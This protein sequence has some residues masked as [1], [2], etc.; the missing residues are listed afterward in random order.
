MQEELPLLFTGDFTLIIMATAAFIVAISVHEAHHAFVATALGDDTP[1]MAGRLTLNPIRHLDMTGV[2][3]FALAGIGWGWTPVNPYKL[4]P[5]PR[6]GNAIVAAA[7]PLSNLALAVV[8]A[9]LYHALDLPRFAVPVPLVG[10]L[11]LSV[12]FT[13]FIRIVAVLNVLLFVLNLIP[14]PP[15]DGFSVLLG[16]L[17]RPM[18]EAIRPIE[19]YGFG[20]IL[21]LLFAPSLLFGFS[22]VGG[23]YRPAAQLLGLA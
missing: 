12:L 2:L 23:L 6:L 10:T 3:V 18:A 13:E 1:R 11:D 5:N 9:L 15:L 20:L 7:G 21:L 14:I 16:L 8:F 19:R 4:R 22:I 17:P